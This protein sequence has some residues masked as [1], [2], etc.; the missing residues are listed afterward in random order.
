ML[1]FKQFVV[2]WL[3]KESWQ[4]KRRHTVTGWT[5]K[6]GKWIHIVSNHG[7]ISIMNQFEPELTN[8]PHP[9]R[10][11]QAIMR[12]NCRVRENYD[13]IYI[14]AVN[15]AAADRAIRVLRREF[16]DKVGTQVEIT[17]E[18]KRSDTS[19][20]IGHINTLQRSL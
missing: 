3:L 7:T 11:H 13:V 14:D 19:P 8:P 2:E 12:G 16:P 10:I 18:R 4:Q 20:L 9:D 5:T 6:L 15:V 17:I 1:S